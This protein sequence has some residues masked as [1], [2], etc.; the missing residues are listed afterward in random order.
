MDSTILNKNMS[1]VRGFRVRGAHVGIKSKRRDLALIVSDVPASAAGVFTR[2][3]VVAEPVKIT[4]E[5]L[6]DGIGQAIIVT[7]GNANACT[8]E[9]ARIS[10]MEIIKTLAEELDIDANNVIYASTGVI[11]VPFPT[12]MVLDGIKRNVKYLNRRKISGTMV[13]N[14]IM[15]TDTFQKEGFVSF[16]LDG[17]TINMAGIAK[18]AGM[19]HP[20]MATMLAF[21]ICD[22]AIDP[23]L[24]DR[25]LRHCVDRSFN[26]ITVDGDTSTNDTVVVMSNGMAEN[27][28][29]EEENEDYFHFRDNLEHICEYLAKAIVSDG[30]GATKF[31]E[32]EVKNASTVK[33][34]ERIVRCV[35]DSNLVKTAIFGRDPNWGRILA[36]VGRS[37]ADFDPGTIDI[38]MG[39]RTMVQV[40]ENGSYKEFD[41]KHLREIL[42]SSNVRILIDL[43]RGDKGALG[44]GTDLSYEYVRINA[45][46]TT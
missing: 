45:E 7:S 39:S 15:T 22:A 25:A 23:V 41:K 38:S 29:I 36:A 21:I 44:W 32:Y 34:A 28:L 6:R 8:G 30:E 11:G 37:G 1:S 4:R 9:H 46:Y 18:G 16:D 20:D 27:E 10:S 5:N 24:L 42:R 12:D 43:K 26:M 3:R 14:A 19:I 17:K 31:I 2:N 13:A 40:A 35:S 33:D